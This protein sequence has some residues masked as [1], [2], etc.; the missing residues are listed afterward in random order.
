MFSIQYVVAQ[1]RG[2]GAPHFAELTIFASMFQGLGWSG[3]SGAHQSSSRFSG[4]Y[5]SVLC[6]RPFILFFCFSHSSIAIRFSSL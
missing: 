2:K 5:T 4:Y 6:F 1:R 3:L